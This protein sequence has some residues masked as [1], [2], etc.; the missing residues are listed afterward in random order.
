MALA[1]FFRKPAASQPAAQQQGGQQPNQDQQI[2]AAKQKKPN[3]PLD[4]NKKDFGEAG[5]EGGTNAGSQKNPLDSFAGMYDTT[6]N[7]AGEI[8]P[9]VFA[10]DPTALATA[11][12]SLKFS[13]HVTPELAQ[14]LQSGDPA[15]LAEAFDAVGRQVY[16]TVMSHQSTLTD[17]FVAARMDHD[18]KGLGQSVHSVLTA[19]SLAKLAEQNPVLKEHVQEIGDKIASKFP[20]ASPEWIANQTKEYFVTMAKQLDPSLDSTKVA[21]QREAETGTDWAKWLAADQKN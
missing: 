2:A 14:K 1:D 8:K 18:R 5:T 13:S 16:Q 12:Q 7:K 20:D 21:A 3:D 10:L 11:S 4:T 6:A 19:N 17:R 15:A 9:P